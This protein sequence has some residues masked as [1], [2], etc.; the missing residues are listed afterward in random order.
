MARVGKISL[1]VFSFL[2]YL[3]ISSSILV[4][5][6]PF[7]SLRT[8][9][10]DSFATTRHAYLLRPLSLYTLSN[11][12]I[13]AHKPQ[14]TTTAVRI[15]QA[16]LN[17]R[18][19]YSNVQDSNI[20]MKAATEKTFSANIMLIH[21]PNRVKV[22]VTKDVGVV[23]QSVTELAK[24]NN[25]VAGINAGAFQD[26]GWQGTGGIP[27]GITMHD[28]HLIGNDPHAWNQQPVIGITKHGQLIAGPYSLDQLKEL[29]VQEAISFG[30]VLV[31]DGV[32]LVQGNGGWG[33]APRT[34]IGQ[35]PDGTIILIVTDGRFIHG[36][37]DAGATLKDVQDLMLQYGATIAANLDGGSSTTMYYNGHLLN[38]PTDILGERTV[39]TA[40]VVTSK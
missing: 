10:L 13:D 36:L 37:N 2:L 14:L 17:N 31:K 15:T 34:A 23:G 8:Y 19:N 25:A 6:G 29:D 21:D 4:F 22:A 28:G 30:P 12:V 40:F 11:S 20:E 38:Q 1:W 3:Y 9:V 35:R 5:H 18:Q 39:A 27:L 26:T 7:Q 33:N 16:D 32:G 24:E